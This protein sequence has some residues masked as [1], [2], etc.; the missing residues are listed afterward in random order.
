MCHLIARVISHHP[1][2]TV[3][4]RQAIYSSSP[5]FRGSTRKII[6]RQGKSPRHGLLHA[7]DRVQETCELFFYARKKCD[8]KCE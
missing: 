6:A 7:S 5:R 2:D 3:Y 4:R 8:D 1:C